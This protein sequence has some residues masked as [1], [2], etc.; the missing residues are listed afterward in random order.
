[1]IDDC[2]MLQNDL[3]NLQKWSDDWLLKFHCEKCKV[4]EVSRTKSNLDYILKGTRKEHVHT[5]KD[6][7]VIIDNKLKFEDHMNEKIKKGNCVVAI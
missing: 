3:N 1:M 7:G 2:N 5:E 6:T 4:L